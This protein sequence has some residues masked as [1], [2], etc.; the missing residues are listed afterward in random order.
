M[1]VVR[2]LRDG[3][4]TGQTAT[5]RVA[6]SGRCTDRAFSVCSLRRPGL[7]S[8]VVRWKTLSGSPALTSCDPRV[9]CSLL[10][11]GAGCLPVPV[12][13]A[14]PFGLSCHD[15]R[16][17]PRPRSLCQRITCVRFRFPVAR[18]RATAFPL[19][20]SRLLHDHRHH[21]HHHHHHHPVSLPHASI[22]R[23]VVV[24]TRSQSV[25]LV[26]AL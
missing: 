8:R 9:W 16:H 24:I 1:A 17:L 4:Q 11:R 18:F 14:L 13:A 22:L 21:H 5:G 3:G 20:P 6:D 23:I 26:P 15:C 12:R 7:S 19:G 10:R 25:S 2:L